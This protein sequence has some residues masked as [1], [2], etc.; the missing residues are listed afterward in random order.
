MTDTRNVK[1]SKTTENEET[2]D[3]AT[4]GNLESKP[5]NVKDKSKSTPNAGST[6]L[7]KMAAR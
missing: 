5:D 4:N 1:V 2:P 7:A 3:A 6:E